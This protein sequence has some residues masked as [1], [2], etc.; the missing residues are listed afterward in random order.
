MRE[1]AIGA[2]IGLGLVAISLLIVRY[3]FGPV[4]DGAA[5]GFE[6]LLPAGAGF[7]MAVLA[8]VPYLLPSFV[9]FDR[10]AE[11]RWGPI[12]VNVFLGWTLV[13]WVAAL[14]WAASLDRRIDPKTGE[15]AR[16]KY[17]RIA[18]ELSM[19]SALLIA[20]LMYR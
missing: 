5:N 10:V 13:G 2:A 4:L 20:Y 11:R 18:F 16:A 12:V 3:G 6:A 7:A 1:H 14:A 17:G 15:P 19:G 8:F 9:A